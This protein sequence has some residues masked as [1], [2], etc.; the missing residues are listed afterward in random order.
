[1]TTVSEKS[2][3]ELYGDISPVAAVKTIDSLDE[4]CMKD[5]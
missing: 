3:R 5:N 4:N 2:L 1:M